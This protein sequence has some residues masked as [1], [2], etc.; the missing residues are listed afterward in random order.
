M[1][2]RLN[3]SCRCGA[4]H[5]H[6]A[7]DDLS[8][9]PRYVCYCRDCQAFI[10]HLLGRSND[11]LDISGGTEVL[12]V[13]PASLHLRRGSEHL[14]CLDLRGGGTLRW[15]TACCASPIGSTPKYWGFPFVSLVAA[16]IRDM[17]DE[18]VIGPIRGRLNLKHAH[19]DV[20]PLEKDALPVFRMLLGTAR[21][22][23]TE[24]V[25]GRHRATP[26]FLPDA[27]VPVSPPHTLT[28]QER[29]RAYGVPSDGNAGSP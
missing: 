14:R 1:P 18:P 16:F 15:F 11:V 6:V 21:T 13:T 3:L 5:G 10:H 20:A 27:S 24:R 23:L 8:A 12:H 9:L 17:P 2:N 22:I 25:S 4:V 7:V 29:R 26:F 28:A 19:G